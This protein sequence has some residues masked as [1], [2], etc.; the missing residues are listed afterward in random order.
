MMKRSVRRMIGGEMCRNFLK[1][2][3]GIQ[4]YHGPLKDFLNKQYSAELAQKSAC[5]RPQ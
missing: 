5:F 3:S 1:I 2:T 4:K